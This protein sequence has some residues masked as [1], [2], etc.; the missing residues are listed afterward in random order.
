MTLL[1]P[2]SPPCV[3][4]IACVE[5][6][7]LP[8]LDFAHFMRRESIARKPLLLVVGSR[9][10]R[11]GVLV[12]KAAGEAP[13][14]GESVASLALGSELFLHTAK[15]TTT[16]WVVKLG[17]RVQ[18]VR[19]KTPQLLQ[20]AAREILSPTRGR[21]CSPKLPNQSFQPVFYR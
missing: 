12:D 2:G 11:L 17:R 4:G 19:E 14:G 7:I 15:R 21:T 18:S 10:K 5:D 20:E 8:V 16:P 6:A 1:P 13:A 3:R 9:D